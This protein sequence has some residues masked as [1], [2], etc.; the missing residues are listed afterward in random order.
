LRIST[1]SSDFLRDCRYVYQD[2]EVG[3]ENDLGTLESSTVSVAPT[4]G[5][6]PPSVHPLLS[7]PEPMQEDC[8]EIPT[9]RHILE[10]T[11]SPLYDPGTPG[12]PF[13]LDTTEAEREFLMQ[14][15]RFIDEL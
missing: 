10:G 7:P 8:L 4:V 2:K 1:I 11:P 9:V 6:A 3:S 14:L 15:D 5:M 12:A 13:D